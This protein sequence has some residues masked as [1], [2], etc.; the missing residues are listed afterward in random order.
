MI[1]KKTKYALSA[2]IY[3]AKE[4]NKGQP[5]LISNLAKKERI[6]KKFLELI[7][8]DLKNHGFLQSKRGRSGG[9]LLGKEPG[10]ITLGQIVRMFDG[11]LAPV[12]CVS[13][14]AYRKCEECVDEDC[15]GIRF[16]MKDVRDAIANILDKTTLADVLKRTENIENNNALTYFI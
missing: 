3:L 1:S 11:P 7:L 2:L 12:S 8:L 13:Q 10:A 5:V 9:Y 15:C 4:H 6:P 14:S 16:V